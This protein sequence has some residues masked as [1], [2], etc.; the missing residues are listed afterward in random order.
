MAYKDID[1]VIQSITGAGLAEPVAR[2]VPKAV[3]KG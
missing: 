3:L 1:R 2:M